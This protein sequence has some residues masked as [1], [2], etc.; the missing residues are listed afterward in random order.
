MAGRTTSWRTTSRRTTSGQTTSRCNN[1]GRIT[2]GRTT[3]ERSTSART[4]SGRTT[5]GQRLMGEPQALGEHRKVHTSY[6]NAVFRRQCSNVLKETF[7]VDDDEMKMT[8]RCY[9][10]VCQATGARRQVPGDRWCHATGARR[11]VPGKLT[12]KK[13]YCLC[14]EGW[15]LV[16]EYW[17]IEVAVF[18]P[19][20]HH[21]HHN[22]HHHP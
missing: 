9:A 3:S 7:D 15:T 20:P 10:V 5:S 11:Q 16:V 17:K 22:H 19:L 18:L 2:S 21:H 6:G 13:R 4:T 12:S 14:T 8:M 1:S